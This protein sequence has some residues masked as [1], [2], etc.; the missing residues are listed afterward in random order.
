[1]RKVFYRQPD[2][3]ITCPDCKI[4]IDVRSL[5]SRNLRCPWCGEALDV[6]PDGRIRPR[7]REESPKI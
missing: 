3:R 1:M 7:H 5:P 2:N 4:R 6:V